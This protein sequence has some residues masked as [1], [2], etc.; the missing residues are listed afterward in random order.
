MDQAGQLAEQPLGVV[1][2]HRPL[3]RLLVRLALPPGP[4]L[5]AGHALAGVAL[6]R[7]VAVVLGLPRVVAHGGHVQPLGQVVEPGVACAERLA[8]AGLEG[9]QLV[10]E[11]GQA[12]FA[13]QQAAREHL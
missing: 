6:G 8:V 12:A 1:A 2:D 9:V 10:A 5:P 11:G 4:V 7:A 3:L 13:V